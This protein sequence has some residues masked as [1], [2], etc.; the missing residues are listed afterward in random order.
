VNPTI[1][2]ITSQLEGSYSPSEAIELAFAVVEETTGLTR[3]AI[4]C[5]KDTQNIPNIEIIL[6]RL[7]KKEPIEYIF[8]HK[9]WRG[10]DL[11]VTPDT[12]IP[13]P[14]TAELLDLIAHL[15]LTHARVLDIG[16]GSGCIAIALKQAHPDWEVTGIDISEEALAVARFNAAQN[17]VEVNWEHVDIL[18]DEIDHY[19]LIVSN[20]PYIPMRE[21]TTMESNVV[22]YEPARALFVSD[23]DPLLFYRTIAKMRKSTHLFFEIHEKYGQEVKQLLDELEYIDT[24]IIADQYGKNRFIYGRTQA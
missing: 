16:T 4:L 17:K 9:Q 2:Y 6:Q 1:R 15:S 12:L 10:L 5:C 21:K 3:T 13:R 24:H 20:P 7:L 19:D 11:R 18:T 8:G 22:D 14:E 23:D